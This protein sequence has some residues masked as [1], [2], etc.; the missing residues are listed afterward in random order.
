MNRFMIIQIRL[1]VGRDLRWSSISAGD[2]K[3]WLNAE[4]YKAMVMQGASVFLF[5]PL[6]DRNENAALEMLLQAPILSYSHKRTPK[7][8]FAAWLHMCLKTRR[9]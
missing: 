6:L 9:R 7:R 4:H 3:V 5:A 1:L 2:K 8:M